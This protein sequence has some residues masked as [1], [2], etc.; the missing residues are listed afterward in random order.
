M[1]VTFLLQFNTS[2]TC[3]KDSSRSLLS[4][5]SPTMKLRA[6]PSAS[7]A[8]QTPGGKSKQQKN[9]ESK[10]TKAAKA[11]EKAEGL[12]DIASMENAMSQAHSADK[13]PRA[14]PKKNSKPSK[15]PKVSRARTT[16]AARKR[17][18][19][20]FPEPEIPSDI[21][22]GESRVT[23]SETDEDDLEETPRPRGNSVSEDLTD[24]EATQKHK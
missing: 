11:K 16:A 21:D 12:R 14:P 15:S 20:S 22:T 17:G 9:V 2:T 3:C 5:P 6:R 1:T 7:K 10:A 19:V 24:F 4:L 23:G 8:P 18:K 13:T